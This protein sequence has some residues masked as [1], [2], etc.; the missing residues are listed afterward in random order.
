VTTEFYAGDLAGTG[1]D[2]VIQI[3]YTSHI[4]EFVLLGTG[5]SAV[6][7]FS[8]IVYDDTYDHYN[9]EE[10]RS[11]LYARKEMG[12]SLAYCDN[13][14]PYKEPKTRDKFFGSVWVPAEAYNHHWIDADYFGRVKLV[15]YEE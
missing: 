6:W 15:A 3:D 14:D 1:W 8:L 4:Y 5:N 11:R 12:L 7:E 10:S 2:D 9:P 13:D